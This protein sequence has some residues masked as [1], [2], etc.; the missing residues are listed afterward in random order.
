MPDKHAVDACRNV[1]TMRRVANFPVAFEER[2]NIHSTAAVYIAG[3]AAVKTLLEFI[4]KFT[5]G[6]TDAEIVQRLSERDGY[7]YPE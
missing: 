4:R 3:L 7:I 6:K 2:I 5:T 1:R